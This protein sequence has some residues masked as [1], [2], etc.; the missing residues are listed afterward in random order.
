MLQLGDKA[1]PLQMQML[2][3]AIV[4]KNEFG[5][6]GITIANQQM[7]QTLFSINVNTL[8]NVVTNWMC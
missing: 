7:K 1:E 2:M 8:H 6:C 3:Q 4:W 5:D